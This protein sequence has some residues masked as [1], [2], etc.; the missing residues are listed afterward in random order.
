M[1][2]FVAN[3]SPVGLT[4]RL[5]VCEDASNTALLILHFFS[6]AEPSSNAACPVA[7]YSASARYTKVRYL[8]SQRIV[9]EC[10]VDLIFAGPMPGFL[11]PSTET[12]L[13]LHAIS[14]GITKP[15]PSWCRGS[16][17]ISR[18]CHLHSSHAVNFLSLSPQLSAP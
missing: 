10:K 13:K 16:L 18:Y 6:Q 2:F 7:S 3:C 12:K 1:P 8:I 9:P 11:L 4:S 15:Y 5:R 14:V 17:Q